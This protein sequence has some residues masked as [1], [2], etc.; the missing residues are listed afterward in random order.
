MIHIFDSDSAEQIV[1]GTV[2]KS[3]D[4]YKIVD[5]RETFSDQPMIEDAP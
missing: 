1:Y 3:G 4:L 5:G 2:K